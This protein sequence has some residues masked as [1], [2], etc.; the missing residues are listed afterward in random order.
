MHFCELAAD[1]YLA[2][3]DGASKLFQRGCN[4]M[5]RFE[6]HD[7]PSDRGHSLEPLL[8]I[9]ASSGG[10]A[11]KRERRRVETGDGQGGKHRARARDGLDTDT[12]I[13]RGSDEATA[14]IRNGRCAG[15]RHERDVV[16]SL[17][18]LDERRRLPRF[19]VLVQARRRRGNRMAREE[20]RRPPR[21]FRRDHRRIAQH[22]QGAHGD[23]FEVADGS[24]DHEQRA[25]HVREAF[26][27]PLADLC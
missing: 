7:R 6:K 13:D 25:G 10:K 22:P 4:P 5:R 23:V 19:V 1:D 12:G 20:L 27:V 2:I 26:I 15:V 9:G 3:A 8:S 21:V 24:G 16:A 17:Q 11:K 14:R 18:P